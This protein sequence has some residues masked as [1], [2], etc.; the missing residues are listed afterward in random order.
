MRL[1]TKL[2]ALVAAS[3]GALAAV[4]VPG[5]AAQ[6]GYGD[7]P[8]SSSLASEILDAH[9]RERAEFGS[10]PLA[11]SPELA[12]EARGWANILARRGVMRHA[13]I[14]ER[15]G[16]GEN[17]WMGTA[18]YYSPREM[19]SYFIA[20]K[21]HFRRGEFPHISRTGRWRDVGHYTQI[22]WGDTRQVGCAIARGKRDE[23]L[24][25]RY[26]PAGNTYGRKVG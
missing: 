20:E 5:A 10:Q 1:G 3:A 9:N 14:E 25:C 4:S 12:R 15:K 19:I 2:L 22:V 8:S 7:R 26:W 11:W 23:F 18:G 6:Q 16:R 13:S 17:L 21:Q 24:V